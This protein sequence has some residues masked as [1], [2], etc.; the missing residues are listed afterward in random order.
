M[1]MVR[2][3][4]IRFG[5]LCFNQYILAGHVIHNGDWRCSVIDCDLKF[6]KHN[7]NQ[8]FSDGHRYFERL[9]VSI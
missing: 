3:L 1:Y 8:A 6:E 7:Y 4:L 9:L 5:A 2:A